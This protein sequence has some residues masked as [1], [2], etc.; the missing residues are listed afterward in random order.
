[1]VT[2][3][4]QHE[5]V[6]DR[7]RRRHHDDIPG[8]VP[9][10]R[11]PCGS[12]RTGL[13]LR[14]SQGIATG[15]PH[16]RNPVPV[17][18]DRRTGLKHGLIARRRAVPEPMVGDTRIGPQLHRREGAQVRRHRPGPDPGHGGERRVLGRSRT[19]RPDLF[20]DV[21]G[22]DVLAA[23]VEP[24][25][26]AVHAAQRVRGRLGGRRGGGRGGALGGRGLGEGVGAGPGGG[27]EE[28]LADTVLLARVPT[29]AGEEQGDRGD[30]HDGG[31]GEGD[32]GSGSPP[33]G[34]PGAVRRWARGGLGGAGEGA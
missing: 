12:R 19:Q 26:T 13:S 29:G 3:V 6:H 24:G 33:G 10:P 21:A 32:T 14:T 20:L 1:M 34:R 28:D 8:P 31:G 16:T 25:G 27:L 23:A 22:G 7:H 9:R 17:D 5:D 30:G 15:T 11:V 4:V 18:K 2:V